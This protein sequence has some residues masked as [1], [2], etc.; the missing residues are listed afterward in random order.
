MPVN[1]YLKNIR[2]VDSA[3]CPACGDEDKMAE[4]FLLWCPAYTHKRWA[5]IEKAKKLRKLMEIETILG[6]PEM[7]KEVAKFIRAM[8]RFQQPNADVQ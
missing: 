1:H 4:H 5:L 8:N 6:V 2:R 3:R 7:T